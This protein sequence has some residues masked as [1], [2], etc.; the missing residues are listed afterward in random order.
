M[1]I[2]LANIQLYRVHRIRT[3][4]QASLT[5]HPVPGL[6]GSITQNLGRDSVRLEIEGIFYGPNARNNLEILRNAYKKREPVDFLADIVGQAYF[7]QVILE[8]FEVVQSAEIPDQFSY[9]LTIAESVSATKS[10][11]ASKALVNQAVKQQAQDLM[12]VAAL[13]DALNVGLIPELSNP[14]EPL[15]GAVQRVETALGG[16]EGPVEGLQ[17]LFQVQLD[18]PAVTAYPLPAPPQPAA[19]KWGKQP[20]SEASLRDLLKAGVPV[21]DLRSSGITAAALLKA[22]ASSGIATTPD[23]DQAFLMELRQA[24]FSPEELS[25]AGVSTQA[26]DQLEQ[27]MEALIWYS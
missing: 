20:A 2:E 6:E 12:Q 22:R 1:P 16:I 8:R 19:L 11:A 14:V 15:T 27:T 25:A 10:P 17:T 3:L 5:H 26:L 13:T 21:K 9:R 24:G 23:L 18:A 4:E 7:S